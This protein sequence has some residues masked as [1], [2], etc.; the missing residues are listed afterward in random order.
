MNPSSKPLTEIHES[1]EL[2]TE[3]WLKV[4][5]TYNE[6]SATMS[7]RL[8]PLGLSLLE[9]EVLM[10]LLSS[11]DLTQRE[12]SQRCFSAKSGIS[13]L[14]SRF[15]AKGLISRHQSKKDKRA[16]SLALTEKGKAAAGQAR[17]VQ[18]EVVMAMAEAFSDSDLE[19]VRTKMA[20]ATLRLR[21][22]R[23]S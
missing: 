2:A 14:V 15:E 16:W 17:E 4:V 10:N 19:L 9:H 22:L 13:M 12:L 23:E 11:C 3:T 6:C 7:Q 8:A 20:D 1:L 18:D 5:Q 21:L